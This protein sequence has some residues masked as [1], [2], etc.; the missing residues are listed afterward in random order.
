MRQTLV[1]ALL[2]LATGLAHASEITDFPLEPSV[3]T[4]AEVRAEALRGGLSAGERDE[5]RALAMT[6]PAGASK[7]R[8]QVR[9]EAA[10]PARVAAW[11]RGGDY[12][13]G[14]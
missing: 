11:P 13:G 6:R 7:T 2:T 14:M 5:G 4:R 8:E 1:L 3:R 12:V 10:Q 9:L